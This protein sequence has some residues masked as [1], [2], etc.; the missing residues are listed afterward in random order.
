MSFYR[1]LAELEREQRR[2]V[3]VTVINKQGHGPA[4]PGAKMLVYPDGSSAGTVGG[5]AIEKAAI[6]HALKMMATGGTSTIHYNLDDDNHLIDTAETGMICG[7]TTSLF[8]EVIGPDVSL[9]VYGGGHIGRAMDQMAHA[10]GYAVT[11]ADCRKDILDGIVHGRTVHTP[12]YNDPTAMPSNPE[13]G[14]VVIATHSHAFDAVVLNAVL[15]QPVQPNYIGVVASI[16]KAEQMVKNIRNTMDDIDLRHLHMPVGL[17]IGGPSPAEIALSILSEIQ[18]IRYER[19]DQ[20]HMGP[21][22]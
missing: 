12:D 14:Y 6:N 20:H 13:G 10:L 17:N 21:S 19:D 16:K 9:L 11:V 18:S 1:S 8:Y 15:E 2:G 22:W 3:L 5:G 4:M 7:G